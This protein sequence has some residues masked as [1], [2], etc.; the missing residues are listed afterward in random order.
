M[1]GAWQSRPC[2]FP[3]ALRG[4]EPPEVMRQRNVRESRFLLAFHIP[5]PRRE[6]KGEE[7]HEYSFTMWP[8]ITAEKA[9]QLWAQALAWQG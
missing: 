7:T 1:R 3:V 8:N 6:R 4:Q 5:V 9:P 2:G